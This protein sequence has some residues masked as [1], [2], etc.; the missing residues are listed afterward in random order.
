MSFY[1][2]SSQLFV[3]VH[4]ET[5]F[6]TELFDVFFMHLHPNCTCLARPRFLYLSLSRNPLFS[7][8][9]YHTTF[10]FLTP[11]CAVCLALAISYNLHAGIVVWE[12]YKRECTGRSRNSSDNIV[13]ELQAG[14]PGFDSRR[15]FFFATASRPVVGPTHS[16]IQWEPVLFLPRV[17]RPKRRTDY[18][19][20]SSAEINTP[21]C[22]FMTWYLIKCG[23]SFRAVVLS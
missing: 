1:A 9:C 20:P 10:E 4:M 2:Y 23:I 11:S 16:P 7:K 22:V 13:T 14:R 19:S 12:N 21:P 5:V 18:S 8:F 17:K 15:V 6:D 3:I